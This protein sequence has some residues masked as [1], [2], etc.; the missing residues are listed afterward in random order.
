LSP[1]TAAWW[2]APF[3]GGLRSCAGAGTEIANDPT[4]PDGTP[5]KPVDARRLARLGWSTRTGLC[6]GVEDA[7]EL[8]VKNHQSARL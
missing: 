8:F 3:R 1:A 6:D 5:R 2:A 7:Y 4:K